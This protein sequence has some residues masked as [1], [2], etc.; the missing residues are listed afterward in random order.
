MKKYFVI[1]GLLTLIS[2]RSNAQTIFE[3]VYGEND[4]DEGYGAMPY[5][6]GYFLTGCINSSTTSYDGFLL[7]TDTLGNQK[8]L[9]KFGGTSTDKLLHMEKTIDN[10]LIL[11]GY[12][13][14]SGVGSDDAWLIKTDSL[15]NIL[16]EKTYGGTESDKIY[17]IK[18]M[19]DSGFIAVGETYS[20]GPN[21][22]SYPNMYIIRTDK[23]G[24]TLWTKAIDHGGAFEDVAKYVTVLSSGDFVITG[25]SS[26][27]ESTYFRSDL[28]L[29]KLDNSGNILWSRTYYS[30]IPGDWEE[31]YSVKQCFDSGFV[32][33][34]YAASS[35]WN[36]GILLKTDS[37]GNY[38][39]SRQ[40]SGH[41]YGDDA[42]VED[43]DI[44]PDSGFVLT[45]YI[46]DPYS[47]PGVP[48]AIWK[49]N[50]TG[51]LMWTRIYGG[52]QSDGGNYISTQNDKGFLIAGFTN[53][54]NLYGQTDIYFIKTDSLG[55]AD[56]QIWT[57]ADTTICAGD[58]AHLLIIANHSGVT[59]SWAPTATL[60]N[61]NSCNPFAYPSSSQFYY[62][63]VTSGTDTAID[64]IF[65][66]VVP[67]P[68]TPNIFL[69]NDTLFS[70]TI[71]GNQWYNQSGIITGAT[72][73]YYIPVATGDYY[74]IVTNSNGCVSDTSNIIHVIITE[75][76]ENNQIPQIKIYPNPTNSQITIELNNNGDYTIE[77][78]NL[79]GQREQIFKTHE[80]VNN[81]DITKISNGFYFIRVINEK[82]ITT[83]KL[84]KQ[85]N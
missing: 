80:P 27:W 61:P 7:R 70:N 21:T 84:I 36:Y 35:G 58:T 26:H 3:R 19:P 33:S 64:S 39:W 47:V 13:A 42:N 2:V 20:F 16:W 37:F 65:V 5:T 79:K 73:Q 60:V 23:N 81:I 85:E 67:L 45:G 59:Y 78:L 17:C 54:K 51:N 9:L 69:Q 49:Y 52:S 12:T 77:I 22:P 53:S 57:S 43:V 72:A 14:S 25:N 41:P 76:A 4:Y 46:N 82:E 50:K 56:L 18:E 66:N 44:T 24:D 48:L 68:L 71:S 55:Y 38:Q 29:S 11:C 1:L 8:W 83:Y 32:V 15:G 62:V 75:I 31:G 40:V 34:G 63:T 30:A 28:R 6:N 10:N 74:V